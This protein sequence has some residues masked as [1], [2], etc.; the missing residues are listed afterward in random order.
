MSPLTVT[1]AQAAAHTGLSADTIRLEINKGKLP[2]K[3]SGSRILIRWAD[4]EKWVDNLEDV[5]S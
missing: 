2:A 5:A 1:I 3:K 4:L